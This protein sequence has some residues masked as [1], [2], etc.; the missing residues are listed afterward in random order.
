MA[1]REYLDGKKL[2][3]TRVFV[4]SIRS[5]CC[6]GKNKRGYTDVAGCKVSFHCARTRYLSHLR[7]LATRHH[8]T[9]F[10]L[11]P[12]T[13]SLSEFLG[14]YVDLFDFGTVPKVEHRFITDRAAQRIDAQ[15]KPGRPFGR[16]ER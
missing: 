2:G 4:M 3:G 15:E 9:E 5:R 8:G 1:L 12:A 10:D 14:L 13:N 7:E 11:V 6:E 16:D